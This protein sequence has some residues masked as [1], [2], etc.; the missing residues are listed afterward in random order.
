MSLG[1]TAH[2][3]WNSSHK[4]IDRTQEKKSIYVYQKDILNFKQKTISV[5]LKLSMS[6][7]MSLFLDNMKLMNSISI[8]LHVT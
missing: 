6:Q 4:Q 8:Q 3:N 2:S 5:Y 1:Y 7:C